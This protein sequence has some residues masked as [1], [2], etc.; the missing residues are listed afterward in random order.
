M[1]RPESTTVVKGAT[2]VFHCKSNLPDSVQWKIV[3]EDDSR[4]LITSGSR[5]SLSYCEH[6]GAFQSLVII[7]ITYDDASRYTCEEKNQIG[8][9]HY[10]IFELIV[11]G[12]YVFNKVILS[13]FAL[14]ANL[15][16]YVILYSN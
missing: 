14:K 12:E 7:N 10:A 5:H 6:L 15:L 16:I 9:D 1:I 13:L 8:G 3:T 11:I 2:V 4:V